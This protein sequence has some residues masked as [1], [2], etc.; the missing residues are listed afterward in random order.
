MKAMRIH[1]PHAPLEHDDVPM[2]EP[3]D[4]EVLLAVT[5]CGVCRTDL[6]V[7]DAELPDIRYPRV[8]GHEIVGR[9]VRAGSGVRDL[10]AGDRVGVPWLARTCGICEYCRRGLENL[11]E[12]ALF[13]GYTVD[14]GYAECTVADARYCL[15]LP[16]RYSDVE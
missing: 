3:G 4:G 7:I 2:P 6:H 16:S 11:C 15:Q 9:V 12:R 13:T 14:G 5:A 10:R 8:P 1:V